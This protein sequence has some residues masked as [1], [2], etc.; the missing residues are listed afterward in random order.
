MKLLATRK[1]RRTALAI[2]TILGIML[3]AAAQW[4]ATYRDP[5]VALY[6][7]GIELMEQGDL[8]GAMQAF[9]NSLKAYKS[10]QSRNAVE[11][12]LLPAPSL[13]LAALAHKQRGIIWIMAQKPDQAVLAFKESIKLNPGDDSLPPT[14]RSM[15]LRMR[16]QAMVVIYDLELLFKKNP[17]QAKGQGKG[18]PKDGDG[19]GQPQPAPGNDPGKQPGKGNPNDI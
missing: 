5:Q 4:V 18:Q 17:E 8:Q 19:K 10:E 7:Q 13:E 9:D 3:L 1:R 15:T 11:R 16:E 2:V 12:F 6:N 14:S